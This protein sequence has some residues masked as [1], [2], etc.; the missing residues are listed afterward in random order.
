M[1]HYLPRRD[2]ELQLTQL[3]IIDNDIIAIP[4]TTHAVYV[5]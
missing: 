1:F 5:L 2:L 3:R 4:Q